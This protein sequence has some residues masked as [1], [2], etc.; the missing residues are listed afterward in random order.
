MPISILLADDHHI[1]RQGLR[2]LIEEQDGMQVI[3]EAEDGIQAVKL[4][5]ELK[6]DVVIMDIKM[7]MLNGI[8][9]TRQIVQ[10]V[11]GVKVVALTMHSERQF[12][13]KMREMGASGYLLKDCAF[14]ELAQAIRDVAAGGEYF[15]PRCPNQHQP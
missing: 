4:A 9:A 11:P 6:P 5:R 13:S 1:V 7:P 10:D 12:V 2:L 3:G 14:E 15:S 8:E